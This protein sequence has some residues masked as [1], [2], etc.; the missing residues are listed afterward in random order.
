MKL[1]FYLTTL[2]L[3]LAGCGSPE[4]FYR[5][6]AEV[7]ANAGS[8]SAISL[9]V[10]PVTLPSYI[11]RA[12]LVYQGGPNEFQIP[13]N[14]R[15]AGSLRD[16]VTQVLATDLERLLGAGEVVAYPWP[17]GRAPHYSVSVNVRQ[18]HAVSGVDA[19]LDLTWQIVN[20]RNGVS[21]ARQSLSLREPIHGDGYA[22][23]VAAESR[24]LARAAEQIAASFRGD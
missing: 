5:L 2:A 7:P 8:G 11:D 3:F 4:N 15:W 20:S 6:S 22:A 17:A 9:G 13:P 12:E 24:L 1:I 21:S 18:F 23:V 10:G 16:N 19:L 14:E